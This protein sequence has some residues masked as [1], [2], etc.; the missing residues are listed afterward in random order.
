MRAYDESL[1]IVVGGVHFLTRKGREYAY[2]C[3]A[4]LYIRGCEEERAGEMLRGIVESGGLEPMRTATRYTARVLRVSGLVNVDGPSG[5]GR[6]SHARGLRHEERLLADIAEC[7]PIGPDG[8]PQTLVRTVV[9]DNF[10][11]EAVPRS[12]DPER[13]M[14]APY[15]YRETCVSVGAS[16]EL[17]AN[18]SRV[19][20]QQRRA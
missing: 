14:V 10:D 18:D 3:G 16:G 17:G 19:T 11:A 5:E 15:V 20:W 12:A 13:G 7:H 9:L 1:W 4:G 6:E 8:K 2:A